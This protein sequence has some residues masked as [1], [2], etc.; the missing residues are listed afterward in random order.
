MKAG[1]PPAATAAAD[2]AIAAQVMLAVWID[3]FS[4]TGATKILVASSG[5]RCL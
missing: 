5:C 1:I 2:P 4:M 3:D